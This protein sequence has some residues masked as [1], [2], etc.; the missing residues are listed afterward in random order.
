MSLFIK[1]LL[2]SALGQKLCQSKVGGWDWGGFSKGRRLHSKGLFSWGLPSLD[3]LEGC[4][5]WALCYSQFHGLDVFIVL[6]IVYSFVPRLWL[7]AHT[8]STR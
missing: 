4:E 6:R 2:Y 1:G 8:K 5:I 3:S 7:S